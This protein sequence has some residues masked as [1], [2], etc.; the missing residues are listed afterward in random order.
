MRA[1]LT[2]RA[3]AAALSRVETFVTAFAAEHGIDGDEAARVLIVLE[4]LLTNFQ[5]YGHPSEAEPGVADV[6]LSLDGA[7]LTIEFVDDGAPFDPLA[8]QAPDLDLSLDER[9]VGGLGIHILRALTDEA[10]YVRSESGNV[11][12]LVRNVSLRGRR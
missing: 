6:R 10:R 11:V 4:E 3:D 12:R 5:K 2:V 7:R 8:R 1:R 9:P